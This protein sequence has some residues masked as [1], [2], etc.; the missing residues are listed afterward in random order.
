VNFLLDH[1]VPDEV[2]RVLAQAGHT[3]VRVRDAM[4]PDAADE[5]VFDHAVQ[6]NLV[7]VTYNRDD[8]LRLTRGCP[9]AGLIILIRR[10]TRIAECACII[11]LLNV[12][13]SSGVTGNVNFA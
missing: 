7:L 3:V 12:A 8:F 10:R 4:A 13:G 5:E 2:G 11:R 6:H 1:D 9:H